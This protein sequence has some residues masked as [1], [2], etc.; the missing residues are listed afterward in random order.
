METT[1][2]CRGEFRDAPDPPFAIA[3]EHPQPGV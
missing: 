3:A 2:R 1:F